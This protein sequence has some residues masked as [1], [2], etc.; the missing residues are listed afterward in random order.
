MPKELAFFNKTHEIW[1]GRYEGLLVCRLSILLFLTG[2]QCCIVN[3]AA[4][5]LNNLVHVPVGPIVRL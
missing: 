3:D 2:L 1:L 5:H 4:T